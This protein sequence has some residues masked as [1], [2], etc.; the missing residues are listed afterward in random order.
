[1]TSWLK[2]WNKKKHLHLGKT[3]QIS[4]RMKNLILFFRLRGET[5]LFNWYF[6]FGGGDKKIVQ[7]KASILKI[8]PLTLAVLV[9]RSNSV[10]FVV[11]TKR[12]YLFR[13]ESLEKQNSF[14][15]SGT[16]FLHTKRFLFHWRNKNF[17]ITSDFLQLK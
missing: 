11:E 9:T 2:F 15:Y 12:F 10:F 17:T 6:F 8:V 1:M 16:F 4:T 13:L 7:W 5:T 3:F 14:N